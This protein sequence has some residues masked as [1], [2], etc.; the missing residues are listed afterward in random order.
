M[1]KDKG[2]AAIRAR[3]AALCISD[4]CSSDKSCSVVPACTH[5]HDDAACVQVGIRQCM[6]KQAICDALQLATVDLLA[7]KGII[8]HWHVLCLKM[9][10]MAVQC[11]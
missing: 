11:G 10:K 4:S 9:T 3:L 5:H 7:L 2:A 1:I 6:N 8:S